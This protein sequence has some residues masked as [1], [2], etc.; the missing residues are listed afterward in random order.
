MMDHL[1]ITFETLGSMADSVYPGL[2][3]MV[4]NSPRNS[5]ACIGAWCPH[6]DGRARRA[7]TE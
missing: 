1:S 6:V 4:P 5:T 2:V 3:G 7:S